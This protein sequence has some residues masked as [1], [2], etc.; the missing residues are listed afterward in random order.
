MPAPAPSNQTVSFLRRRFAE[1]GI[2]PHARHG[3]NFLIDLNLVRLIVERAELDDHDVVLEVGTGTGSLTGMMA[4]RVAAMVTVEIDARLYQLAHEELF[5]L[6]NVVMLQQ[7]A[8]RNKSHFDDRVLA[9]VRDQLAAGPDR[10]LKLVANL[11]YS[12]ATPVIANLLSAPIVPHSMTVTVQKELADRIAAHPGTRDY[13]ALSVWIQSQCQ[14]ELVRVLPPTV[15]WPRPKVTS[16]IVHIQVDEALRQRIPDREFFHDFVRSLFMHR[17]KFLRG[18]LQGRWK[19]ELG[20]SGI[21]QALAET[22]LNPEAR[23][24]QLDIESILKLCDAFQRLVAGGPESKNETRKETEG[25]EG[26][27]NE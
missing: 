26:T 9:A 7:D 16:A 14:V 8:L 13:G 10:R 18:V 27:E 22:E 24:E 15:F 21:D 25:T 17:R 4:S 19:A 1:V 12:V 23:A 20:K 6:T 11:P 5:G 2:E 3:Q